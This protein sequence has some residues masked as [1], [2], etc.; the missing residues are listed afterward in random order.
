MIGVRR[1]AQGQGLAGRLLDRVHTLSA[2]DDRS[3][4]V[5][6]TTEVASNVGLYERF[7]YHVVGTADVA[8]AFTTW[9]MYRPDQ[10]TVA[11]P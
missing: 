1:R 4:G 6:L 9:A 10:T 5:T 3:R 11:G 2:A 8:S 7:G